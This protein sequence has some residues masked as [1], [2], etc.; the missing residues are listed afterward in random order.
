MIYP[1]FQAHL[2]LPFIFLQQKS[3]EMT[4]RASSQTWSHKQ[5]A[6]TSRKMRNPQERHMAPIRLQKLLEILKVGHL[7]LGLKYSC[8]FSKL[9]T[10]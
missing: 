10:S 6:Q 1:D 9:L 2:P 7:L 3:S 4:K 5:Q 8:A